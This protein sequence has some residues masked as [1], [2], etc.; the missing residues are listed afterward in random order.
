LAVDFS[1]ETQIG[2]EGDTDR[3]V[4]IAAAD[5]RVACGN[6]FDVA[7]GQFSLIQFSY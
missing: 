4:Q 6:W 3:G 1:A 7:H 2:S 5:K